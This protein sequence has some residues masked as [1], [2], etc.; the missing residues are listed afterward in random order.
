[1]FTF[2]RQYSQICHIILLV[3]E[4]STLFINSN[5]KTFLSHG[6]TDIQIENLKY[7]FVDFIKQSHFTGKFQKSKSRPCFCFFGMD[8][9]LK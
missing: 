7:M 1:M 5:F 3:G 9:M 2:Y 8:S 4:N 6:A